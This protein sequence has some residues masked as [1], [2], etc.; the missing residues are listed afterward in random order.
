MRPT[1]S[2][3]RSAMYLVRRVLGRP[4][5]TRAEGRAERARLAWPRPK[6]SAGARALAGPA[7][8]APTRLVVAGTAAS[9]SRARPAGSPGPSGHRHAPSSR[10]GH[11]RCAG[12][13][14]RRCSPSVGPRG[15]AGRGLRVLAATRRRRAVG[16]GHAG[17]AQSDRRP[18][19]GL[20]DPTDPRHRRR[21]PPSRPATDA[22]RHRRPR[23]ADDVADGPPP[24][25]R[26]RR[27]PRT[28]TPA[29]D[30]HAR[31]P[32]PTADAEA[33]RRR[34]RRHPRHARRRRPTDA[35]PDADARPREPTPDPTPE[36]TPTPTPAP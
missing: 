3:P 35:D 19:V 17:A 10:S 15:R 7:A 30:G 23:H 33:D 21:R 26:H 8:V 13:A 2:T 11:R 6:R 18:A 16:H 29:A 1:S 5:T 22:R 24:R 36:P 34:R 32:T 14:A 4:T 20:A 28:A 9:H 25:R 31:P 27:R 12:A